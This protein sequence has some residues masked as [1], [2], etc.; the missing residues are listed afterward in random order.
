MFPIVALTLSAVNRWLSTTVHPSSVLGPKPTHTQWT[1][2]LTQILRHGLPKG[3]KSLWQR[4]RCSVP[5]VN[6]IVLL[7]PGL[8]LLGFCVCA[9]VCVYEKGRV[10]VLPTNSKEHK[11]VSVLIYLDF[12]ELTSC[13]CCPVECVG[14][15]TV[16]WFKIPAL[17][18]MTFLETFSDEC[19]LPPHVVSK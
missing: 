8:V 13:C 19:Q 11:F 2:T 17:L 4:Q 1:H 3:P 18:L 16:L 5:G 9:S 15:K 6:I 10:F 14:I 7:V 12:H